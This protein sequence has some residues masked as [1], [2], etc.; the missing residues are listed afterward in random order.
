VT[1][2][3]HRA[4]ERIEQADAIIGAHLRSTVNTGGRCCYRVQ[5]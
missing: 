2:A 3:I 5:R 1:R 4:L